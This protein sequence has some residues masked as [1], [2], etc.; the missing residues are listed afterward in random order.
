MKRFI[1]I[2]C[3]SIFQFATNAQELNCQVSIIASNKVEVST[4]EQEIFKQ[5]EEIIRQFMNETKWTKDNFKL[6]ER[7]SCQLQFQVDK[8]PQ[9]GVYEG[10]FQ[11]QSSRPVFNSTYNT[12]LLNYR[13]ENVSFSFS[14][15]EML[16]FSP[17]RFTNNLI[18][19]LAYY[20]YYIIGIDYDSF[21][22][23]GGTP[24]FQEAQNVVL[25]AQSSGAPGWSPDQT[26]NKNNRYWVIDN[27]MHQLFEPLREC[28][29]EY[30][31]MGLDKLSESKEQGR[32]AMYEALNKL[33][34]V[35]ATR[36]NT[37]NVTSFIQSKRIELKQ[38][39]SDA[40][41]PEKGKLVALL[42]RLDPV[43]SERY[44]EI[45]K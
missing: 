37:I 2:A 35:V 42:K 21:G 22:L 1:L 3:L 43:G 27:T 9:P 24:H 36:P 41:V 33:A 25:N 28:Y 15:G 13:D 12:V 44:D 6:E 7:I 26:G 45:L 23:K 32:A 14:R 40:P 8:I 18:S 17:N 16:N 11:I 4:V 30:H 19:M 31:R 38:V 34:K 20:A 10:K 5:L 39:F 29:Y